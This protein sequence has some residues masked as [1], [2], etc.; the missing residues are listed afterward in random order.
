MID[1]SRHPLLKQAYDVCQAIE[2]CGASLELT[3]AVTKASALMHDLGKHLAP[4]LELQELKAKDARTLVHAMTIADGVAR[5]EVELYAK[6]RM[7]PD[8]FPIYDLREAEGTGG[9]CAEA[10]YLAW[11]QTAQRAAAYIRL[12]GDVWPWVMLAV[13]GEQNLVRFVEKEPA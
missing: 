3:A 4:T 9:V 10:D 13:D 5:S 1:I 8:G 6:G 11:A 12:R 2:A 7:H